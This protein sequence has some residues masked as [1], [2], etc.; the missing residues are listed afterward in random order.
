MSTV[1]MPI[2]ETLAEA[3]IDS[4]QTS[5]GTTT[6]DVLS[7]ES[8]VSAVSAWPSQKRSVKIRV[9]GVSANP[10]VLIATI[11]NL[12]SLGELRPG[13]NSYAARSIRG[14]VIEHT[15]RWIPTLLQPTTPEPAVVPRVRGG[16]QLEWH[17]RG[18][19]LEIYIGSPADI[20]F[21]AED[22]NSGETVEAPLAGN[23]GLL[24]TWITRISD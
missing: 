15:A 1:I 18:V 3:E 17:R 23:E 5:S 4:T 24:N 7:W 6:S 22:L 10:V 2:N 16:I 14:D 19:D 11:R 21:E 9:L 8:I 12:Y 13:W 20:R